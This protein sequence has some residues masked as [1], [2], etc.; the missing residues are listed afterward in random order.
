[1][2]RRSRSAAP[3]ATCSG[4]RILSSSASGSARSTACNS[5]D[6]RRRRQRE[7][8]AREQMEDPGAVTGGFSRV[9]LRELVARAVDTLPEELRTVVVF[10]YW[11]HLPYQDIADKLGI[12]LGTVKSQLSRADHILEQRLGKILK[13]SEPARANAGGEHA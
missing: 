10:R 5:L 4:W 1:M 7:K 12:P 13:G 2:S 3:T 6:L 11:E 9:D 8:A